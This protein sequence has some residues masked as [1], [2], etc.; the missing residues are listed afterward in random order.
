MCNDLYGLNLVTLVNPALCYRRKAL[1]RPP[2]F[3]SQS[4]Q[5]ANSEATSGGIFEIFLRQFCLW[6]PHRLYLHQGWGNIL[7]GSTGRCVIPR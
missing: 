5:L 6:R 3:G 1:R 4:A 7:S 2:L